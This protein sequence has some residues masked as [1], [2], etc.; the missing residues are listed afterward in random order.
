M[1]AFG[2]LF[3]ITIV[4]IAIAL[5]GVMLWGVLT[6]LYVLLRSALAVF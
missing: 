6:V 3:S 1:K 2:W 4:V 5:L